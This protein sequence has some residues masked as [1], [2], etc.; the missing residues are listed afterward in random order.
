MPL[1]SSLVLKYIT[2]PRFE[3]HEF[4]HEPPWLLISL[5]STGPS[6]RK[7]VIYAHFFLWKSCTEISALIYLGSQIDTMHKKITLG[8]K[9]IISFFISS[10]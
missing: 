2:W 10:Y 7:Y 6:Y 5:Y 9:H 3:V 1:S 8:L 4:M